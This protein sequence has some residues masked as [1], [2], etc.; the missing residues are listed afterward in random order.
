MEEQ[1]VSKDICRILYDTG[2]DEPC[3]AYMSID[4]EVTIIT[5]YI[6]DWNSYDD[7]YSVPT[8]SHL[9]DWLSFNDVIIEI[10]DDGC[11]FQ[12]TYGEL[13]YDLKNNDFYEGLEQT[14]LLALYVMSV[15]SPD[16]LMN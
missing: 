12:I 9:L 1:L 11:D 10:S 16:E 6:Y 15:H 5:P 7:R 14:A 3:S 2:F 8:W 13:F 4:G